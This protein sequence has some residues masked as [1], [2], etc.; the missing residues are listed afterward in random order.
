[1]TYQQVR[2]P[3]EWSATRT[4]ASR[5]I[6]GRCFHW[7]ADGEPIGPL[8]DKAVS[9]PECIRARRCAVGKPFATR[10]DSA[11]DKAH[12]IIGRR[13]PTGECRSAHRRMLFRIA[14]IQSENTGT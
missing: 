14:L 4:Q 13:V 6:F 3:D 8:Y 12:V 9:R 1:M 10:V 11:S 7:A 5:P 2:I